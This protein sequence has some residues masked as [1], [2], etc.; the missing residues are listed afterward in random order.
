M[1]LA[2]FVKNN[3]PALL[4]AV[5][6]T[7]LL[8]TAV[9]S[10]KGGADAARFLAQEQDARDRLNVPDEAKIITN[11]QALGMT[12]KYFVPA[13]VTATISI[14]CLVGAH[15]LSAKKQAALLG[16]ATLSEGYLSD[17]KEKVIEVIGEKA[18]KEIVNQVATDRIEKAQPNISQV[19]IAEEEVWCFDTITSR[20]FK[21]TVERLRRAENEINHQT[22]HDWC[23]SLNDFYDKVGLPRAEIGEDI[24]WNSDTLLDLQIT[25]TKFKDKP[26]LAVDYRPRPTL[27]FQR[28]F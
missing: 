9:L 2:A 26:M 3:T 15:T 10:A 23:A 28:V 16:I 7:G 6:I 24:G 25:T 1:S 22:Q 5:G 11:K 19:L 4:T 27:G 20:E 21:S 18:E 13:G 14:V 17:Y 12:W 8:S